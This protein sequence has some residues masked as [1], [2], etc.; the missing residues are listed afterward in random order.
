SKAAA[1]AASPAVVPR[2]PVLLE[3]G[4]PTI[5]GTPQQ[6][7]T[8]TEHHGEWSNGPTSFTYEWL[9]CGS[10]GG[11]CSPIA[12]AT[13]QTYVPA[14]A[15]VGHTI[16]VRETASNAGGSSVPATSEATAAV[17]P[18]APKVLTAPTITGEARQCQTL[19]E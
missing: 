3:H 14:A 13:A 7:Q 15:D 18:A 8:L 10:K 12:G 17:L 11:T 16:R 4:Q 2:E 6:G 9:Q 1:S 19:A 5:T